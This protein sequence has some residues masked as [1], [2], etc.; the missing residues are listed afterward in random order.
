MSVREAKQVLLTH[1]LPKAVSRTNVITDDYIPQ[2]RLIGAF[3]ARGE[4]IA[5]A[6]HRYPLGDS[7]LSFAASTGGD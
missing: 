3:T 7:H 6:S 2:G 1:S 4:G 5:Q